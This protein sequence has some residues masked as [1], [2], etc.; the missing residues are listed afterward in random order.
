MSGYFYYKVTRKISSG[1]VE[2]FGVYKKRL[3]WW[4]FMHYFATMDQV[5]DYI[6]RKSP[7]NHQTEELVGYYTYT[8]ENEPKV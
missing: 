3:F 8:G 1:G 2:L 6:K 7:K 4:E 5:R